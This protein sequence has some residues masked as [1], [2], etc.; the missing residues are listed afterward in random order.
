MEE[1]PKNEPYVHG[2]GG[3]IQ[4]SKNLIP[5]GL[6]I[7]IVAGLSILSIVALAFLLFY[8]VSPQKIPNIQ[9][10]ILDNSQNE[11]IEE[12]KLEERE[13]EP[14]T[15]GRDELG[16]YSIQAGSFVKEYGQLFKQ[17]ELTVDWHNGAIPLTDMETKKLLDSLGAFDWK[18]VALCQGEE[19]CKLSLF[20]A[21]VV[22]EPKKLQG[23][24]LYYFF[25]PEMG[26]GLYQH[27]YT[28][29]VDP[30]TNKFIS[31]HTPPVEEWGLNYL[32][33]YIWFG[34]TI[35]YEFSE[36][37]EPKTLA[38]AGQKSYLVSKGGYLSE[39]FD[40]ANSNENAGGIVDVVDGT[41]VK[42]AGKKV[43]DSPKNGPVYFDGQQ[44]YI[45]MPDGAHRVYEYMPYFLKESQPDAQEKNFYEL[46]YTADIT[47]DTNNVLN[48]NDVYALGGDLQTEGCGAGFEILS[49]I[50]NNKEW[51]D[52]NKLVQIGKTNTNEPIYEL[53]DKKTNSY[54]TDLFNFGYEGSLVR[55]YDYDK[56]PEMTEEQK[57][58][59]FDADTPLFFWKDPMGNWR[60]YRKAKYQTLA[61]CGKPVIYLYPE[62]TTDVR[63]QVAPNGGFTYTDPVYPHDGWFVRAQPNGQL[64]N[65]AN[66]TNYTYLFWEGH[67]D[68]FGFPNRGFVFAQDEVP[69]GMRSLLAKTG[70]VGQEI[71]DF[72]EFWQDKMMQKPYVFVTFASEQDFER[73]APLKV[74]P[75]PNTTIRV[76]M[77]FD[78]LDA[79]ISV[80]PLPIKTPKRKG[81]TVVEWG[82]VLER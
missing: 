59:D 33:S 38:L 76:F 2:E 50:V 17:G 57:R 51:F 62:K 23:L 69:T 18:D 71:E 6:F 12:S 3:N 39:E 63:V 70:L 31:I 32:S 14:L 54:Y 21:G 74:T 9:P 47:W 60:S 43:F 30:G 41:I 66:K 42:L 15:L 77:K 7:G 34:G 49:N 61:E 56:I 64:Y 80:E 22:Q 37:T 35:E 52:E 10:Q 29:F 79:P 81:F 75:K 20:E 26:M 16:S 25:I 1:I 4:P 11:I 73:S 13:P 67:A 8:Q 27:Q 48:T 36:L 44:Y 24:K 46:S 82:G 19:G 45:I 5:K 58:A 78:L 68:G 40:L 53:S 28:V 72:M 55:T 65:Y